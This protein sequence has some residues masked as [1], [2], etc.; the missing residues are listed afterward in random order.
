VGLGLQEAAAKSATRNI[1]ATNSSSQSSSIPT[2]HPSSPLTAPE[3]ESEAAAAA[4][5]VWRAAGRVPG[6]WGVLGSTVFNCKQVLDL[7]G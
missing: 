3:S 2:L 7:T 5:A 6:V 1:S 4:V